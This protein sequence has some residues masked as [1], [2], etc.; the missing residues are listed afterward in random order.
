M[1]EKQKSTKGA[2][3]AFFAFFAPFYRIFKTSHCCEALEDSFL[4][5]FFFE[6][7]S[8]LSFFLA[9]GAVFGPALVPFAF[10]ASAPVCPA[11]VKVSAWSGT[12]APFEVVRIE[13]VPAWLPTSDGFAVAF[14]SSF[15]CPFL[16]SKTPFG[17]ISKP[18]WPV[19][20]ENL[21]MKLG[22]SGA[23]LSLLGSGTGLPSFSRYSLPLP[24]NSLFEKSRTSLV[25]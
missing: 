10:P 14:T 24:A 6:S 21:P 4:S 17:S 18:L 7:L 8:F 25:K 12:G 16:V 23:G 19:I 13:R 2:K 20:N 9:S 22:R 1:G 11:G 3:K 15:S 5:F